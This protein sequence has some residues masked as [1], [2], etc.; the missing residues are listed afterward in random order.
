V[1]TSGRCH[2]N[3]WVN[4][5]R[6]IG[7]RSEGK[8]RQMK[9]RR[10]YQVRFLARVAFWIGLFA[11]VMFAANHINW[12]GDHYCFKTMVECYFPEGK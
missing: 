1:A 8:G 10:Y 5:G 3:V 6:Q 2:G 9:T 12:M 4:N 7:G 11:T